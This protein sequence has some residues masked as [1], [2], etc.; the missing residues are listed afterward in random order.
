MKRIDI[1]E[2]EKDIRNWIS[3]HLPKAYI[4]RKLKCRPGTLNIYLSK[5]KINYSGNMGGKGQGGKRK[6]VSFYLK[7]DGPFINSHQLKNILIRDGL[8]EH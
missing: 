3:E 5:L 8:K 4:C 6:H 1:L 2:K 7:K